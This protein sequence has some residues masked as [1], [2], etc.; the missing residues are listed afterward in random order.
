MLTRQ[1]HQSWLHGM[2]YQRGHGREHH[3]RQQQ[4]QHIQRQIASAV[5]VRASEPLQQPAASTSTPSAAGEDFGY[6]A[7][8]AA[9]KGQ[10]L[11]NTRKSGSAI[12]L[13]LL[14]TVDGT[15]ALCG[16]A[17][18]AASYAY[19]SWL[20]RDVD[21]VTASDTVPLWEANKVCCLAVCFNLL[22]LQVGVWCS[23]L[24]C[25]LCITTQNMQWRAD[26]SWSSPLS[27]VCRL[28]TP[29]SAKPPSCGQLTRMRCN[30]AC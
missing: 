7:E 15:A 21:A 22:C 26:I 17:G 29:S 27:L 19:L 28:K 8:Y 3:L 18:T 25:L 4:Q 11:D 5:T 12:G 30:L 20:M 2:G 1:L 10:L 9:L 16:M 23:E 6:M 14:L 13:Y 24:L